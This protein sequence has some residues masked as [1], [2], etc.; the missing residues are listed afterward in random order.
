MEPSA[1]AIV[2]TNSMIE[3]IR[4]VVDSSIPTH[5]VQE[6]PEYAQ[7][8]DGDVCNVTNA[9]DLG[10]YSRPFPTDISLENPLLGL[11][12]Q[13]YLAFKWVMY[14]L[15]TSNAGLLFFRRYQQDRKL[16][17]RFLAQSVASDNALYN[18]RDPPPTAPTF[19][20]SYQDYGQY[21]PNK[22]TQPYSYHGLNTKFSQKKFNQGMYKNNSFNI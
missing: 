9:Q 6:P 16:P 12:P 7:D 4:R 11:S 21:P 3:P 8:L 15:L 10:K 2:G 13:E 22:H 19:R 14:L 17:V 20:T 1:L 18:P 5:P